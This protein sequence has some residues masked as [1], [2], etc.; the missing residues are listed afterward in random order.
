[1]PVSFT[2]LG[3]HH[4]ML[5]SWNRTGQGRKVF[6]NTIKHMMTPIKN[7]TITK[8]IIIII[9][10]PSSF[11][12]DVFNICPQ[13]PKSIPWLPTTRTYC[14][15]VKPPRNWYIFKKYLQN[16]C[17]F[18]IPDFTV[19][20]AYLKNENILSHRNTFETWYF[21]NIVKHHFFSGLQPSF[22]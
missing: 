20:I 22:Q 1:M 16:M 12:V 6:V 10:K 4:N 7:I 11:P 2:S 8:S 5:S 18:S 17:L 21:A 3:R 14:F 13:F 15:Q 19:N 9:R